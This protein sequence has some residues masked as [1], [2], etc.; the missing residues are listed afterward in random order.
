MLPHLNY[1]PGDLP[2]EARQFFSESL[3]LETSLECF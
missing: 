1:G 3:S 2:L